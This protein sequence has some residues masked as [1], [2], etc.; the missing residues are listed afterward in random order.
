MV[1]ETPS[2]IHWPRKHTTLT[3]L[4]EGIPTSMLSALSNAPSPYPSPRPP[5]KLAADDACQAYSSSAAH[6]CRPLKVASSVHIRV[7]AAMSQRTNDPL[8]PV[9]GCFLSTRKKTT[10]LDNPTW[11]SASFRSRGGK[12]GRC[13]KALDCYCCIPENLKMGVDS[14]ATSRCYRTAISKVSFPAF[15]GLSHSV[16]SLLV[17]PRPRFRLTFQCPT[18]H[19]NSRTRRKKDRRQCRLT[20]TFPRAIR[21]M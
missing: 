1:Y 17:C 9:V 12:I 5:L 8:I 4:P 10:A 6:R 20:L 15:P 16:R 19:L 18:L 14:F 13:G 3:C 2:A 21:E 11:I 7:T